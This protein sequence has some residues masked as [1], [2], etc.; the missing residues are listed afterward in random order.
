MAD[1]NEKRRRYHYGDIL[2]QKSRLKE[3]K[4]PDYEP[5]IEIPYYPLDALF[6]SRLYKRSVAVS[7]QAATLHV[8]MHQT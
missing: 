4:A 1:L 5:Y 3:G 8:S 6:I 2:V 7:Q